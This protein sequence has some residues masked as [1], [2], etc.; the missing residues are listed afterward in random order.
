MVELIVSSCKATFKLTLS[1][2]LVLIAQYS[3]WFQESLTSF[4]YQ[5]FKQTLGWWKFHLGKLMVDKGNE[6]WVI[7]MKTKLHLY[8][9][10]PNTLSWMCI[11]IHTDIFAKS[12][13][14]CSTVTISTELLYTT[15]SK[16]VVRNSSESEMKVKTKNESNIFIKYTN[17]RHIYLIGL[18]AFEV[19]RIASFHSCIILFFF[20]FW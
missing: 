2:E 5:L 16:A 20:F 9:N 17:T 12:L 3:F 7:F 19:T 13:A 1:F 15:Q 4:H 18:F 10:H 11:F 6:F 14:F 8:K